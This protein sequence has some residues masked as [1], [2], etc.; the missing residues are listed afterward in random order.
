MPLKDVGT[1]R[2]WPSTPLPAH[3]TNADIAATN[4]D[5]AGGDAIEE[6]ALALAEEAGLNRAALAALLRDADG[7]LASAYAD[8]AAAC[9][10]EL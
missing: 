6:G 1:A 7:G 2:G 8:I 9:R 5:V 3:G 4:V 10:W